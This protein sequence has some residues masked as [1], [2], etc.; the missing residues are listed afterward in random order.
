MHGCWNA[1]P[2][3]DGGW[4]WAPC[5]W[6]LICGL[7]HGPCGT[8]AYLTAL[9]SSNPGSSRV[10]RTHLLCYILGLKQKRF[11]KSLTLVKFRSTILV[12]MG[13][14]QTRQQKSSPN[15]PLRVFK[16]LKS[17]R[18]FFLNKKL[19][20]EPESTKNKWH[21]EIPNLIYQKT[22]A[23]FFGGGWEGEPAALVWD[24]RPPLFFPT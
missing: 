3:F 24:G 10:H 17:P 4:G 7:N 12:W 5:L 6:F 14:L 18:I 13:S 20:K 8:E 23:L 19:N 2:G 11:T 1:L 21:N 9:R 16:T 15:F 22:I